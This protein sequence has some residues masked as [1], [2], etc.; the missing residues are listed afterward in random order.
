M[1]G[2][3]AAAL[4]PVGLSLHDYWPSATGA[5]IALGSWAGD[6]L[7]LTLP[8]AIAARFRSQR[9]PISLPFLAALLATGLPPLGAIGL[10]SPWF[11]AAPAFPGLGAMGLGLAALGLAWLAA[12]R[13]PFPWLP[14]VVV[15]SFIAGVHAV[16]QPPRP[17]KRWVGVSLSLGRAPRT[18]PTWIARNQK[19]ARLAARAVRQASPGGVVLLP[20]DIAGDWLGLAD[21]LWAK[22]AASARAHGVTVLVGATLSPAPNQRA[23]VLLAMGKSTDVLFPHQPAPLGEWRPWQSPNP[24]PARPWHFG[25]SSIAG[26]RAALLVCYEQ[27]LVWP[28]LFQALPSNRF[29]VLLAPAN[30]GWASAGNVEPR[31]QRETAMALARLFGAAFVGA[32]DGPVHPARPRLR[33]PRIIHDQGKD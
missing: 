21:F 14:W 30:H 27:L 31:L 6:A 16:W 11:A 5:L 26:Q 13:Q 8:W 7:L 15:F 17:L 29:D 32:D 24:Y 20:E 9:F 22:V 18:I 3:Y 4:V 28:A 25:S 33:F 1:L 19:A 12:E 2:Y 10:A 23:D